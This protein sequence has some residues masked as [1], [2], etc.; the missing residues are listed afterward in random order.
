[1]RPPTGPPG[2]RRP[3]RLTARV[4]LT[5]SYALFAVATGAVTL[6]IIYLAM[7][8]VPNYPLTAANPR[9]TSPA[10]ASREILDTLTRASG[11]ALLALAVIGLVGS[12]IIAGRVLRPLQDLT[13]A[14][15]R[16]AEGALDHRVALPGP[17]DE[18]TDLSDA[19]DHMLGR[20]ERSLAAQ[21]RFAA[22]ASH[23]LRTPLAITRTMLDVAAAD[24]GG[25]DYP[26]LVARLRDTNER[27]IE[28]VDALLH[29]SDLGRT[30]LTTQPV[31]LA[32]AAAEALSLTREEAGDRGVALTGD[33]APALVGG[34]GVL[35]RQLAVNLLQNAV[36][37]NLEAGGTARLTTGPDPRRAG[38]ALLTV[39]NTGPPLTGA[40][41]TYTEPF[42]RGEG[43][44]VRAGGGAGRRG[45]GLGLSIVAGIVDVHGGTL[46]LTPRPT[47]GLT[48]EVS[49]PGPGQAR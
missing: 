42:L 36:R 11:Y 22:N 41:D 25:Q 7:R 39:T 5:L 16:A 8:W 45:H 40:V 1:M 24:P 10:A 43:R 49:L 31:D 6:A 12:W 13:R 34:N 47:G 15:H 19:F 18:F 23:E 30:P 37:H 35:L 21:R 46:T 32:S 14:A 48:A 26:R 20:I 44:T 9:D 27:G 29:L 33:H 4:K 38:H 28:I 2:A 17:R 3:R